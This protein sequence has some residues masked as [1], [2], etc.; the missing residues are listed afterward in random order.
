MAQS[1]RVPKI[2]NFNVIDCLIDSLTKYLKWPNFGTSY[3]SEYWSNSFV[4]TTN[5]HLQNKHNSL[6][7]MEKIEGWILIELWPFLSASILIFAG[8]GEYF[9][10]RFNISFCT[11]YYKLRHAVLCWISCSVIEILLLPGLDGANCR[12]PAFEKGFICQLLYTT[13][14][15]CHV[16]KTLDSHLLLWFT[17][18]LVSCEVI[19]GKT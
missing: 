12:G 16:M 10:S 3:L 2:I 15:V 7:Q 1:Q 19:Y 5:L 11:H 8:S 18:S 9:L 6:L 14:L 4:S 13:N 17:N